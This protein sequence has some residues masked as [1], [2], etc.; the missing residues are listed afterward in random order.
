MH[1]QIRGW[2]VVIFF[3]MFCRSPPRI[4]EVHLPEKLVLQ[5]ASALCVEINS[6]FAG[7]RSV[8]AGKDFKKFLMVC[9]LNISHILISYVSRGSTCN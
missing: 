7:L 4:P 6:A 5:V 9:F 2:V 8:A 1:Q 3:P